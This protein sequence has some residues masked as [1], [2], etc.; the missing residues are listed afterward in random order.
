MLVLIVS[1]MPL[2]AA[3]AQGQAGTDIAVLKGGAEK[4]ILNRFFSQA[5]NSQIYCSKSQN[6]SNSSQIGICFHN[7][8][9]PRIDKNK[10]DNNNN[11][12][13]DDGRKKIGVSYI[14]FNHGS[15]LTNS[16]EIKKNPN[17]ISK[18]R[19]KRYKKSKIV[20]GITKSGE[21]TPAANQATAI[22]PEIS[23]TLS[24]WPGDS[25]II[26]EDGSMEKI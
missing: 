10:V 2:A 7:L 1:Y 11:N 4:R 9:P 3:L 12:T 8:F 13:A 25:F 17:A 20:G 22:L 24:N 18:D 19:P 15:S 5:K 21:I 6:D 23:E 16:I 14:P 26:V